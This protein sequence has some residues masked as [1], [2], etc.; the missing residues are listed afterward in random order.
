MGKKLEFDAHLPN[1]LAEVLCNQTC[2]VLRTPINITRGILAELAELA[3]EIDDPRLHIMMLRLGLYEVPARERVEKIKELKKEIKREVKNDNR[4][5][6]DLREVQGWRIISNILRILWR[7]ERMQ[8]ADIRK[9]STDRQ[10]GGDARGVDKGG[11][12]VSTDFQIGLVYR[13][14]LFR[15]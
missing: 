13:C 15:N 5:A 2:S 9:T 4:L 8:L 10:C 11:C 1:L 6:R 14:E 7:A 12:G 3:I